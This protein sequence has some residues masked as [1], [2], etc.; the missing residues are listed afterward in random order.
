LLLV[1]RFQQKEKAPQQ[2]KTL[3]A[4]PIAACMNSIRISHKTP[5]WILN[6]SNNA[7]HNSAARISNASAGRVKYG[8]R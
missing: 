4:W 7:P 5:N 6:F 2:K 1:C 3:F 8:W